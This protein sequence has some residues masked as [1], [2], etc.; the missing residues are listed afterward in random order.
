MMDVRISVL[1][2][3]AARET[4]G[5]A[6]WLREERDLTTTVDLVPR[7]PV[8]GELG[9]V[10]DIMVAAAGSGGLAVTLVNSLRSWLKAKAARVTIEVK[11]VK[12]SAT[13]DARNVDSAETQ[14][15]LERIL[16]FLR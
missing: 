7:P 2:D 14:A 12:G 9:S 5:L 15:L 16:D 6:E 3:D 1:N 4:N 13:L 10:I 11:T 8:P